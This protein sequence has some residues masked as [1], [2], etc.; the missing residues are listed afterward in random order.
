MATSVINCQKADAESITKA[1][2]R[3]L[4]ADFRRDLAQTV[5]L[6][7]QT[8]AAKRIRDILKSMDITRNAPKRFHDLPGG[9]EA[10]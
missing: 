3:A 7:G 8:D 4:D 6:Y 2:R 9:K 5:S 1:I 10:S